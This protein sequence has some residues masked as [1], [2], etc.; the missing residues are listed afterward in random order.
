MQVGEIIVANIIGL[1]FYEI[2]AFDDYH[3][4]VKC[5]KLFCRGWYARGHIT[6]CHPGRPN[7]IDL[8]K[9]N[10]FKRVKRPNHNGKT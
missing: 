1:G 5:L 10:S 2:H 6:C 3:V 8:E 7:K 4:Q 9:W